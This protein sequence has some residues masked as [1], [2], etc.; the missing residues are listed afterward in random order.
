MF[1]NCNI[2]RIDLNSPSPGK[3]NNHLLDSRPGN[4]GATDNKYTTTNDARNK[5]GDGSVPVVPRGRVSPDADGRR[6]F[7]QDSATP[8]QSPNDV[9]NGKADSPVQCRRCGS[10]NVIE[11]EAS[12]PHLL[13][14]V[15][16]DC[17]KWVG[18]KKTP[19][20]VRRA[21]RFVL[22]FGMFNG[23]RLA[24]L[25]KTERGRN[26]IRWLAENVPNQSGRMAA[27]LMELDGAT[28]AKGGV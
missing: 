17:C 20:N 21:K 5:S 27:I 10:T 25:Q 7:R 28:G 6:K 2:A 12:G 19:S 14:W 1:S 24:E 15:C 23:K 4:N 26:Y 16:G 13:K 9:P 18:F 22:E 8:P 3:R 11:T